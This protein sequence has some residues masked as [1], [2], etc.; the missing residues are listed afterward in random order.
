MRIKITP[1]GLIYFQV[2]FSLLYKS[3]EIFGFGVEKL[4]YVLHFIAIYLLFFTLRD[5]NRKIGKYVKFEAAIIRTLLV[6]TI[7]GIFIIPLCYADILIHI[8]PGVYIKGLLN[9]YRYFIFFFAVIKYCD[10]SDIK[11]IF[12]IL[13][14]IFIVNLILC[15]YEYFVMGCEQDFLGG[16]FGITYGGNVG[17]NAL[18]CFFSALYALRYLNK[19]VSIIS[20]IAVEIISVLLAT[21]AELKIYYIELIVIMIL[22]VLLVKPNRNTIKIIASSVLILCVGIYALSIIFPRQLT[23]LMD[24]DK[25]SNYA[26]GSYVT[27]SLGRIT[28]FQELEGYF[29]QDYPMVRI[30]GFG[31]GTFDPTSSSYWA[32]T[33]S[34]LRAGWFG[35]S[36]ILLNLGYI[37]LVAMY[38][39]YINLARKSFVWGRKYREEKIYMD[40]TI[41]MIV[42]ILISMWYNSTILS[43]T[44]AYLLNFVI[45]VPIIIRKEKSKVIHSKVGE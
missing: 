4:N 33:F 35:N 30:F 9:F 20:F 42:I 5:K 3:L 21:M 8:S 19:K 31:I 25:F 17:L 45:A 32:D 7:V 2:V 26:G 10:F 41:V 36:C 24:G 44:I 11:E 40:F 27:G 6:T 34:Y 14:K 18:L 16:I 15:C 13:E 22:V 43:G 39:F 12:K 29:F 1:K 28:M 23:I 37:G 38:I